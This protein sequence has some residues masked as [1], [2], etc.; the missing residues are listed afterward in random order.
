MSSNVVLCPMENSSRDVQ[1]SIHRCHCNI[2][3]EL[4]HIFPDAGPFSDNILAIPVLQHAR[5]DLVN[6][7]ETVEREKE[8]LL[9]KVLRHHEI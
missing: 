9:E 3:R 2:I 6:M 7:G 8:R 5:C 1:M 4:N